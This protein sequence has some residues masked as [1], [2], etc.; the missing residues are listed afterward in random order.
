MQTYFVDC[1][2]EVNIDFYFDVDRAGQPYILT[3]STQDLIE[4]PTPKLCAINMRATIDPKVAFVFNRYIVRKYCI[5]VQ[6]DETLSV[7]FFAAE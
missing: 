6:F 1:K 7:N 3:L 5:Q 4:R 2:Q